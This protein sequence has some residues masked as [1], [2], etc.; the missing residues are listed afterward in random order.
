ML[1]HTSQADL[2]NADVAARL[3][4]A[5]VVVVS[6]ELEP[7][8]T[9]DAMERRR[10][11]V[12]Q[13]LD[14]FKS[15]ADREML[16]SANDEAVAPDAGKQRA[17]KARKGGGGSTAELQKFSGRNVTPQTVATIFGRGSKFAGREDV[18]TSVH[19]ISTLTKALDDH[20]AQPSSTAKV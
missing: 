9:E 8:F 2:P 7:E 5:G 10:L 16:A 19:D 3:T 6:D 12:A 18:E 14:D 1:P 15:A 17:G 13:M 4:E 11:E 20:L